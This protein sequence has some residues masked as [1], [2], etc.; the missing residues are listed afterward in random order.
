MELACPQA[1]RECGW[2]PCVSGSRVAPVSVHDQGTAQATGEGGRVP[3]FPVGHRV[4]LPKPAGLGTQRHCGVSAALPAL[5]GEA[6]L[7]PPAAAEMFAEGRSGAA[8]WAALSAPG[9][10]LRTWGEEV[11]IEVTLRGPDKPSWTA[12]AGAAQ[13]RPPS[14]ARASLFSPRCGWPGIHLLSCDQRLLFVCYK[15]RDVR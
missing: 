14:A 10:G 5:P 7:F 3:P 6:E 1:V 12:V 15:V 2:A 11:L 4:L 9:L 8:T 13:R